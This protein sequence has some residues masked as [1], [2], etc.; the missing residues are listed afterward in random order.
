MMQV[1]ELKRQRFEFYE[2][3]FHYSSSILLAPKV[4]RK[5]FYKDIISF[6]SRRESLNYVSYGITY[7]FKIRNDKDL[8]L[9]ACNKEVEHAINLI[10]ENRT[11]VKLEEMEAA[12]SSSQAVSVSSINHEVEINS[13]NQIKVSTG[14]EQAQS[15]DAPK[16]I[17]FVDRFYQIDSML[18]SND[19][20]RREFYF[21]NGS[22]MGL[23]FRGVFSLSYFPSDYIDSLSSFGGIDYL[24]KSL[25]DFFYRIRRINLDIPLKNVYERIL[26]ANSYYLKTVLMKYYYT[27][28]DFSDYDLKEL[29]NSFQS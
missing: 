14:L 11:R 8:K 22:C 15:L 17:S 10:I 5:V 28:G 12:K 24:A 16:V 4:D 26:S 1:I 18:M 19:E 7:V 20:L 13:I 3:Y 2:D 25:F 23:T 29:V 6:S 21:G 9:L 27:N